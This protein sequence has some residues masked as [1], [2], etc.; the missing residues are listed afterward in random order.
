MLFTDPL[1]LAYCACSGVAD[2]IAI[3]SGTKNDSSSARFSHC[4]CA[5][6]TTCRP[7]PS[8]QT[9]EGRTASMS[10]SCARM[11][12]MSPHSS[13]MDSE[14]EQ[15]VSSS[16]TVSVRV[17]S[18]SNSDSFCAGCSVAAYCWKV[19]GETSCTRSGTGSSFT[20]AMGEER[21]SEYPMCGCLATV[22]RVTGC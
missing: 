18:M 14:P 19:Q 10:S 16:A 2:W 15:E 11:A 13:R 9:K 22:L 4:T 1:W 7:S 8:L 20:K 17:V 21:K 3:H 5:R 12:G 6:T